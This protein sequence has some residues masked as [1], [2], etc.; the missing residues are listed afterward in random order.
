MRQYGTIAA[1]YLC[2]VVTSRRVF[3]AVFRRSFLV[4][5]YSL[6]LIVYVDV[7]SDGSPATRLVRGTSLGYSVFVAYCSNR[8]FILQAGHYRMGTAIVRVLIVCVAVRVV[9]RGVARYSSVSRPFIFYCGDGAYTIRLISGKVM[10]TSGFI[11]LIYSLRVFYSSVFY[12]VRRGYKECVPT[13]CV[14]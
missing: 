6:R 3:I 14:D 8:F 5:L 7:A 4:G 13:V 10:L 12:V 9:S 2:V 11:Y 1:Y